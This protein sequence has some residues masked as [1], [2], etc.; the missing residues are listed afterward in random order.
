MKTFKTFLIE[1][2]SDFEQFRK[3]K[4]NKIKSDQRE[5]RR[6]ENEDSFAQHML[7][8][9]SKNEQLYVKYLQDDVEQLKRYKVF[10]FGTIDDV[11]DFMEHELHVNFDSTVTQRRLFNLLKDEKLFSMVNEIVSKCKYLRQKTEGDF[12][13][14]MKDNYFLN[15]LTSLQHKINVAQQRF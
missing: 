13:S 12:A 14:Y 8:I 9:E 5:Q 1:Q 7:D 6:K 2:I 15:K 10:G 4:Q 11:L 3:Q